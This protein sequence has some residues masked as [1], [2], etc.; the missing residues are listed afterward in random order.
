LLV[1]LRDGQ[2]QDL[3]EVGRVTVRQPR[4]TLDDWLRTFKQKRDDIVNHRCPV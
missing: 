4:T 3:F 2:L 1:Q